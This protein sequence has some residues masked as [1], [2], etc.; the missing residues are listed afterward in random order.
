LERCLVR[1][2]PVSSDM[3]AGAFLLGG[4]VMKK[5]AFKVV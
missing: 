1:T 3:L 5:S 4:V 2:V